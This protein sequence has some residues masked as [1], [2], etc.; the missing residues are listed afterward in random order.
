M[1]VGDIVKQ[2]INL[3]L[4]GGY[5]TFYRRQKS[6]IGIVIAIKN[7]SRPSGWE[8][9]DYQLRW[10]DKSDRRIDVLWY[11]GKLSK[12]FAESGLE[13]LIDSNT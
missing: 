3:K 13:V 11:S 9:T 4:N 6:L 12:D 8:A 2:S 5:N 1:R 10:A 7:N